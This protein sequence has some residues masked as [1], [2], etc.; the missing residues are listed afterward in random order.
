M[1][2]LGE[3]ERQ[4][5]SGLRSLSRLVENASKTERTK[6]NRPSNR[7][8][9][10]GMIVGLNGVGPLL[11]WK[12]RSLLRKIVVRARPIS[13][14]PSYSINSLDSLTSKYTRD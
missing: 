8:A 13:R 1:P 6:C 12:V 2:R 9:I 10:R 3:V 14:R 11:Q 7:R 4:A 5:L